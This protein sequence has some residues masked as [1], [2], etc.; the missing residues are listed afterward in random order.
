MVE[1]KNEKQHPHKLPHIRYKI[2]ESI[3]VELF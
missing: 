1:Y 2:K 3:W